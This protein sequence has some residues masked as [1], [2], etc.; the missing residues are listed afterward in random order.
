MNSKDDKT[1]T[2]SELDEII[3]KRVSREQEKYADYADLKSKVDGYAK[4]LEEQRIAN[5]TDIEKAQE[6]AKTKETEAETL[7]KELEGL[8]DVMRKSRIEGE[9]AKAAQKA[10][11]EY[12]DAAMK[13]ADLSAVE[14]TEEGV[15]GIDEVVK[16]LVKTNPF[17]LKPKAEQK[18]IGAVSTK[19]QK[20][21]DKSP[22][23][24]LAIASEK[25]RKSGSMKDKIAYIQ[26]KKNLGL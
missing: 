5:M 23:E 15:K 14:V 26:L 1:F 21:N 16:G 3:S 12:V 11:I 9:F 25:A 19:Q 24:L 18:L 6:L 10:G 4:L 17:L 20:A 7:R 8:K 22:Q 2:Q 13:L